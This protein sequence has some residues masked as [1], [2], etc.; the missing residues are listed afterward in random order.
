MR[1]LFSLSKED[2]PENYET[3]GIDITGSADGFKVAFQVSTENVSNLLNIVESKAYKPGDAVADVKLEKQAEI[4]E[5]IW[6]LINRTNS[7]I[8]KNGRFYANFMVRYCYRLYDGSTILH[9]APV[10][11]PVLIPLQG[12]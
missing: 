1:I 4:T 2:Q 3:G 7:L 10:L 6:A 12:I 8:A 11:M 5:S 9:S